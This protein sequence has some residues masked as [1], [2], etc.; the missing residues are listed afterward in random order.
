MHPAQ[1]QRWLDTRAAAERLGLSAAALE[2]Y[3]VIGG[4][5]RFAKFGR[6][7]RYS[8]V[9]LDE[10]ARERERGSTSERGAA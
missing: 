3:R 8:E 10:W 1:Y 9:S 6:A 7:V 4:G 2:K 5:P